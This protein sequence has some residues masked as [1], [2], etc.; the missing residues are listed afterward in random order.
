MAYFKAMD[1]CRA[2]FYY[3][4]NRIFPVTGFKSIYAPCF[5]GKR[6]LEVGGPSALFNTLIPV[7]GIIGELDGCNFA[8]ETLWQG[9]ISEKN[10]YYFKKNAPRGNLYIRDATSLT[11]IMAEQY[12]FL[13]SCHSLE[14]IAN[15]IKALT[16]WSRVLKPAGYLLLVLPDK[17]G[18]FDHNRETTPVSHLLQDFSGGVGEDDLTHLPEILR[19]HDLSRD[20]AAG[21][22]DSFKARSLKNFQNRCLHHHVFSPETIRELLA[23]CKM[24]VLDIQMHP[25][26]HIVCL[27]QKN[28][29]MVEPERPF[30][31]E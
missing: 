16:E 1:S 29:R 20:P 6:G 19:T 21:D 4:L 28:N 3:L 10:G 26:Y 7:Y 5:N 27:A 22:I 30:P 13:L 24:R 2:V 11:G 9:K 31:N 14:H 15:P 18:T 17:R 23:Q 25:P 8:P 12:D